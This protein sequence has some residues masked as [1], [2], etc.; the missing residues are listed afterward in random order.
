[1]IGAGQPGDPTERIADG[2][3]HIVGIVLGIVGAVFLIVHASLEAT[4]GAIAANAAYAAGLLVMLSCSAAYNMSRTEARRALMRRFDHAGIFLMIAGTYTPFTLGRID[5][6]WSIWLAV[7][8][9]TAAM[10]GAGAKLF[11][12]HRFERVAV[13]AYLG[14]GWLILVAIKPLFDAVDGWVFGLIIAGGV[15]Y[16]AGVV[17]HLWQNLRFQTAIWHGFVL[18]AAGCH[19]AAIFIN[20]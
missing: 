15:L 4:G 13:A 10:L 16:S 19:Y 20:V 12:P 5:G 1:M 9:W 11:F 2:I 14:L 7:I 18:S 6:A 8:V 17:F 3:I